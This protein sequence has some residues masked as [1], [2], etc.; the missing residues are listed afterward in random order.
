MCFHLQMEI[1]NLFKKLVQDFP[2]LVPMFVICVWSLFIFL[3][4][5]YYTLIYLFCGVH[6]HATV[7]EY[8]KAISRD[9]FSSPTMWVLG[10]NSASTFTCWA[11]SLALG[12]YFQSKLLAHI[13]VDCENK[14]CAVS[15]NLCALHT[16]KDQCGWNKECLKFFAKPVSH[17]REM[18]EQYN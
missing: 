12:S 4:F 15:V 2:L 3:H 17:K 18:G 7:C 1:I 9:Q 11:I 8:H 16:A 6:V 5:S 14:M 13:F 10:I